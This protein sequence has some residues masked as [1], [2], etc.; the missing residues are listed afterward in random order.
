MHIP[1]LV[2]LAAI[3][4]ATQAGAATLPDAITRWTGV[5]TDVEGRGERV[6]IVL[7]PS[8]EVPA[9]TARARATSQGGEPGWQ[10]TEIALPV[11]TR[12][13]GGGRATIASQ[14]ASA[15]LGE[16]TA[17]ASGRFD[18][19]AIEDRGA[20]TRVDHA[21]ADAAATTG[22]VQLSLDLAGLHTDAKSGAAPLLP[23]HIALRGHTTEA[24]IAAL[25]AMFNDRPAGPAP[26]SVDILSFDLGP[27]SFTGTGTVT[28]V[29][30]TDR[31]GRITLES[32]G[33]SQLMQAAQ[34]D[35]QLIR[36]YPAMMIL[37]QLG[38]KQ[39]GRLVWTAE[40]S[41]PRILVNGLDVAALLA[42]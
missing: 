6:R 16:R 5:V 19:V 23:H 38:H 15:W 9:I 1:K 7:P 32:T 41:G 24:G 3:C 31:T 42:M 37:R 28:F 34:A 20:V 10:L 26:V 14:H 39:N 36:L 12:L 13:T 30:P 35:P 17:N 40:F 22:P 33:F 25:T 27:A 8:S 21:Q 18:G 11:P 4:A 29:S 2:L